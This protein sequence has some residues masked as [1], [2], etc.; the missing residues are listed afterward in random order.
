MSGPFNST[1]PKSKRSAGPAS[2]GPGKTDESMREIVQLEGDVEGLRVRYE[3]HFLGLVRVPPNEEHARIRSMLIRM[4]AV[5][6]RSSAAR[7]RLQ[8]LHNRFLSYERMWARTLREREDGTYQR[9]LAKARRRRAAIGE[10]FQAKPGDGPGASPRVPGEGRSEAAA[11]DAPGSEAR[12]RGSGLSDSQMRALYDAYVGAK[13][14]CNEPTTGLSYEGM[15]ARLNS[16][17]PAL[18]EKHKATSVEFKVL[19]KD[20]KAVLK[21]VPK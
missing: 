18:L 7:F 4:K 14:R 6:S 20:G 15:A 1:D 17:I 12:L 2:H 10:G 5:G 16:Q 11:V 8:T 13:K 3:Q 9:D 19:I 21:A